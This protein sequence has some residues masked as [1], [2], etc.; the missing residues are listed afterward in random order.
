MKNVVFMTE[1]KNGVV[2]SAR[3]AGLH[4]SAESHIGLAEA[5]VAGF[6]VV[7]M[8]CFALVVAR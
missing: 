5:M 1:P 7:A 8:V 4:H 3:L 2:L 6:L